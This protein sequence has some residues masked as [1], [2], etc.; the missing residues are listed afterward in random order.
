MP[1]PAGWRVDS[2]G[3]LYV[4]TNMGVQV[5][6]P[7]GRVN[8]ILPMPTGQPTH[9]CFGG[10][11]FDTLVVTCGD[12]VYCRQTENRRGAPALK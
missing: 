3:R 7:A 5:C 8:C 4:A 10:E 2:D 11:N 1:R 9:L 6:D 12:A